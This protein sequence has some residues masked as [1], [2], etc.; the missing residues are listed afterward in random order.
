M[1]KKP[2]LIS[3]HIP[4]TAGGSFRQTLMQHFKNRSC[5][6]RGD[7]P[8]HRNTL[9]RYALVGR[10]WVQ[11]LSRGFDSCDCIHG[12]FLPLKY[13]P[14]SR[15]RNLKFVCW[16]RDPVERLASHYFYWKRSYVPGRVPRLHKRMYEENWSLERF[17][18]G[19]EL[20]NVYG[21]L[22]SGFDI[23]RF[24]FI[25]IT[26]KYDMSLKQFCETFLN[27]KP[28]AFQ[29]HVNPDKPDLYIRDKVFRRAVEEYHAKDMHLYEM[30]RQRSQQLRQSQDT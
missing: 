23:E 10:A 14:L 21:L 29:N 25:G 27:S 7:L 12:H 5:D 13:L 16:I 8:L 3:V 2:L 20:R 26:E 17:C 24:S 1:T 22:L 4:K 9:S 6:D 19:P 18:L 30:L 15:R 28:I 11:N